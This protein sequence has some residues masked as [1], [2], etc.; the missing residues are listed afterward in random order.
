M[1]RA[2]QIKYK[3]PKKYRLS[4]KKDIKVLFDQGQG[5]FVHPY[6]IKFKLKNYSPAEDIVSDRLLISVPKRMFKRAVIRHQIRRSIKEAWRLNHHDVKVSLAK[7]VAMHYA[8]S[9]SIETVIPKYGL[10]ISILYVANE[11]LAFQ[12]LQKRL[13]LLLKR[14]DEAL[15]E[16][17]VFETNPPPTQKN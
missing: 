16:P 12:Y 13:T 9:S 14:L 7:A 10:D 1:P 2:A 17:S 5:L 8:H 4:S 15:L 11:V 6:R 3:F